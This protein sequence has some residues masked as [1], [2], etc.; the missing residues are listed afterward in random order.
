[1]LYL[2]FIIFDDV[3]DFSFGIYWDENGLTACIRCS[4][5][6]CSSRHE[7]GWEKGYL[8]KDLSLS[9]RKN[10]PEEVKTL[11]H[12]TAGTLGDEISKIWC[13]LLKPQ[14]LC[15][16]ARHFSLVQLLFVLLPSYMYILLFLKLVG[17]ESMLF[18]FPI[19]NRELSFHFSAKGQTLHWGG[20]KVPFCLGSVNV[21]CHLKNLFETFLDW[22]HF[23]IYWLNVKFFP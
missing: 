4:R 20:H 1:M 14:W 7:Q 23:Q 13:S 2:H 16:S 17:T 21:S 10:V 8:V 22:S 9:N 5:L 6:P 3:L 12:V 11:T 15:L 18:E 19:R